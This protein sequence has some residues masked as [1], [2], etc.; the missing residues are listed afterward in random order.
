MSVELIGDMLAQ[1]SVL[2]GDLQK[3][4]GK[5]VFAPWNR[6]PKP[7][8]RAASKKIWPPS[9]IGP[10]LVIFVGCQRFDLSLLESTTML[11]RRDMLQRLGTGFGLVG[12][13]GL[14]AEQNLLAAPAGQPHQSA[15][16]RSRPIF[17][18]KAKRIIHLFMNGGPSQVD[19]F[20]PKPAL[21][22]QQRPTAAGFRS[23]HR[24][25]HR[26]ADDVAVSF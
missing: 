14:L 4:E 6:P 26:R 7:D 2:V 10:G 11:T 22:C 13:A 25:W 23:A 5:V 17:R 1:Q 8:C 21:A 15:G 20:D 24:A 16:P 3:R 12:L 9:G 19:T 18:P